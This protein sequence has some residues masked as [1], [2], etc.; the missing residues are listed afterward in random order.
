MKINNNGQIFK[1]ILLVLLQ[2]CIYQC[3]V[4]VNVN[5]FFFLLYSCQCNFRI[6]KNTGLFDKQGYKVG[7]SI[8]A[9]SV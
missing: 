4:A 7:T 6:G 1:K 3:I 2:K 8:I 9:N 5:I